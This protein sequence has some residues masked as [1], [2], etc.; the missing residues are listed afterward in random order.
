MGAR[1][2]A[3]PRVSFAQGG[4]MTTNPTFDGRVLSRV[5]M[6]TET[7]T[8]ISSI[9]LGLLAL[10]FTSIFGFIALYVLSRP[11][12]THT[13]FIFS[14]SRRTFSFV[15]LAIAALLVTTAIVLAR[16]IRRR[17]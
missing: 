7:D 1:T 6:S 12:L 11:F 8:R 3:G 10:V 9:A 15:L 14:V 16:L 2:C 5:N 4:V 13:D 17:F